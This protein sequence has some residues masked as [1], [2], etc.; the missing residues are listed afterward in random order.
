[1]GNQRDMLLDRIRA[2]EFVAVEINLYLDSHPRERLIST[3]TN[4]YALI[5][6]RSISL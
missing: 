6:S 4:S 3:A 1:M 5:R 2:H